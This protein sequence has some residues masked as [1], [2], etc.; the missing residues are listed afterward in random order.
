MVVLGRDQLRIFVESP[1]LIKRR[2]PN[3]HTRGANEIGF[4]ELGESHLLGDLLSRAPRQSL[5]DC[6]VIRSSKTELL[7]E[8]SRHPWV[9]GI[10]KAEP[11][12]AS[13]MGRIVARRAWP[14]IRFALETHGST[15]AGHNLRCS[16][17]R[18]VIDNQ[19]LDRRI[20]LAEAAF[21]RP[22]Y[23]SRR[24]VGRDNG[25]DGRPHNRLLTATCLTS[26]ATARRQRIPRVWSR[27]G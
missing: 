18:A 22:I 27:R 19:N 3:Q 21:D 26:Q 25:T 4:P 2:A 10:E 9:V 13:Q 7:L 15:K 16:V 24:V 23:G 20:S 8:L 5:N 1:K 14:P 11:I 12:A 17:G 6:Y